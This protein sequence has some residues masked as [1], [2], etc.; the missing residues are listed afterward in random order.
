[1]VKFVALQSSTTMKQ[2]LFTLLAFFILAGTAL[3][4]TVANQPADISHCNNNVFDLTQQTA[5]ILGSQ[6]QGLFTVGYFLTATDANEST[7]AIATP[8]AYTATVQ[9]QTIYARVTKNDGTSFATTSF[10]LI[11]NI[12]IAD[13]RSNATVCGRYVLGPLTV[14][15]YYTMPGGFGAPLTAG[16]V[17][18][19]S[20]TIYIYASSGT[21]SSETSFTVTVN[22]IPPVDN[23][24]D[25]MVCDS[26]T[27][28]A[29]TAGNYYSAAG[30]PAGSGTRL[31][32]GDVIATTQTLYVYAEQGTRVL[33]SNE[34]SFTVTVAGAPIIPELPPF[35]VCDEN[36]D[37]REYFDLTAVASVIAKDSNGGT[38]T[39]YNSGSDAQAGSNP[40]AHINAYVVYDG[41]TTIYARLTFTISGCYAIA[42]VT[43]SIVPCT[44]NVIEGTVTF[45]SKSDGCD[46]ADTGIANAMVKYTNATDTYYT[47]TNALGYYNFT[48]VPDGSSTITLTPVDGQTFAAPIPSYT[49]TVPGEA[50]AT[51]FCATGPAVNDV[52]VFIVP[53]TPA[54][55]G[56]KAA[57]NMHYY[58]NGYQPASG[59]VTFQFDAAKLTYVP[60]DGTAVT[61]AGNTLTLNY[62]GLKPYESR[63]VPLYFTVAQ[64]PVVKSGNVLA[65]TAAITPLDGDSTPDNNIYAY[66][67]VAVSAYDPNDITVSEGAFITKSQAAGYLHYTIRFQNTGTANATNIKVGST[68]DANL[69]WDTFQP[70]G[71]SHDYQ[72][73]RNGDNAEFVFDNI[74]LPYKTADEAASHGYISYRIKPKSGIAAGDVMAGTANIYFDFNDAVITNTATTTIKETA[75]LANAGAKGF[76]IYPNPASA[77]VTVALQNVSAASAH[78]AIT[79]ILG[80]TVLTA[81]VTGTEQT[82]NVAS[83]KSGLY[84]ITLTTAEKQITQKLVI[85]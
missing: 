2:K 53:A 81:P 33:C 57:Y 65:F 38:V 8:Q 11:N 79:D 35:T 82:I 31:N 37:G 61:V 34:K 77:K 12:V 22:P 5:A 63:F 45:D 6:G 14:G 51:N 50:S 28:P 17:I 7:N 74:Q 32:A 85:Q 20:T 25:I 60:A 71:A 47:F 10:S 68:L 4:Q 41:T 44:V 43:L 73:N 70:I 75:G 83:L 19:A 76:M 29:L 26:Y 84:F 48:N 21:C 54:V 30:G 72:A 13:S 49:I 78:I 58:N 18:T 3:G 16:T 23:M 9:K 69:D 39:F 46:A 62:T 27:L 1:M 64:P 24:P 40:L 67:Q 80:K 52:T 66:S 15:N 56:Y 59:T 55:P 36:G 42:P